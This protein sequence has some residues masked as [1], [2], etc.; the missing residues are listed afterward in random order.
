MYTTTLVFRFWEYFRHRVAHRLAFVPNNKL[1]TF[2]AAASQGRKESFPA[3]FIFLH[4][5]S[6]TDYF[7]ETILIYGNG[8]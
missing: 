6:S 3:F 5:F 4:T 2:E 7:T 1:D 8:Y